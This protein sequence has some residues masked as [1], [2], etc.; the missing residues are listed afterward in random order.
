MAALGRGHLRP[1]ADLPPAPRLERAARGAGRLLVVANRLVD[2]GVVAGPW[3][4]PV[5][6]SGWACR[7]RC[8]RRGAARRAGAARLT[9]AEG[10]RYALHRWS[11]RP[12]LLWRV[13]RTHHQPRRMYVLNGPRLH[14]ANHLWVALANAGPMLLLGASLPAVILAANLAVFFVLSSTPTCGAASTLD[15]L[16]ATPDRPPSDPPK[17]RQQDVNFASS[18]WSSIGCRDLPGSAPA[19]EAGDIGLVEADRPRSFP[20]VS[21]VRARTPAFFPGRSALTSCHAIEIGCRALAAVLLPARLPRPGPPIASPL[22]HWCW[23]SWVRGGAA[24]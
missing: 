23:P 15:P 9:I 6:C 17:P 11:H 18:F 12:G 2:V 5:A 7:W 4:W 3:R 10:V 8:G 13:H 24:R 21:P 20:G 19:V 1:R 22:R 14:P 16:L